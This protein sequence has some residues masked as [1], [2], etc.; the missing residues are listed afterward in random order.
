MTEGI[1][2]KNSLMSTN[3][4]PLGV[5]ETYQIFAAYAGMHQVN[6]AASENN[7]FL[8]VKNWIGFD[9]NIWQI[10]GSVLSGSTQPF[11]KG[12]IFS[13][14]NIDNGIFVAHSFIIKFTV[15]GT[16]GAMLFRVTDNQDKYFKFEWTP[17]SVNIA[18]ITNA[19][20]IPEEEIINRIYEGVSTPAE[21]IL[22]VREYKYTSLDDD[23]WLLIGA[24]VNGH[25]RVSA[26]Y[27]LKGVSTGYGIGFEIDESSSVSWDELFVP[28]FGPLPIDWAIMDPGEAPMGA[29]NRT[30]GERH[31]KSYA[32]YKGDLVLFRPRNAP[33]HWDFT[34]FQTKTTAYTFD[35]S[36]VVTHVRQW[37]AFHEAERIWP[38]G[39]QKFGR[40]FV[41]VNNPNLYT[42]ADCYAEAQV[43][44][45]K[46]TEEAERIS[47]DCQFIPV[48]EPE[49]RIRTLEGD[50]FVDSIQV[51][52]RPSK[53]SM[54]INAR[55][56]AYY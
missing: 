38:E 41:E 45:N 25:Q 11:Q 28:Q 46:S 5:F 1:G 13:S 43:I 16:G 19:R 52:V 8:K 20:T 24:W 50:W 37:G 47:F 48:I 30:I 33:V 49:D 32:N 23:N 29:I 14:P 54:S 15:N 40:R 12:R 18:R 17:T 27:Q 34:R 22:M 7:P 39:I 55:R 2:F 9:D 44:I 21:V 42:E 56:F 53:I 10:N 3:T 35:Y 36:R 6:V 4:H 51:D 26:A 31:I